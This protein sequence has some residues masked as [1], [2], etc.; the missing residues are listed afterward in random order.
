MP[1]KNAAAA[2]EAKNKAKNLHLNR[3]GRNNPHMSSLVLNG[4]VRDSLLVQ[5]EPM[6]VKELPTS[7]RDIAGH[8]SWLA[9][10]QPLQRELEMMH[11]LRSMR[12]GYFTKNS[13]RLSRYKQHRFHHIDGGRHTSKLSVD[14]KTRPDPKN[15]TALFK[16]GRNKAGRWIAANAKY[17]GR[18]SSVSLADLIGPK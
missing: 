8:M 9:F 5:L 1:W 18:R 3:A 13:S 11:A 16:A 7:A 15:L 12:V 17:V 2:K 14:S 4:H 10:N 6:R